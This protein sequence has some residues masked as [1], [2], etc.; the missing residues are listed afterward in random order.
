MKRNWKTAVIAVCAVVV[1]AA[2]FA[3]AA[4][5]QDD[6]LITLGYLKN[7]FTPQIETYVDEA[8]ALGTA[9]NQV[10]FDAALQEWDTQVN[11][12]IE[13]IENTPVT[14]N[15]ASFLTVPMA[16]GTTVTVEAGCELI[17]RTGTPVCSAALI[18]QTNGTVLAAGKTLTA[19]H[20]YLAL[21]SC[22]FSVPVQ[23]VTGVIT[24]GPLN[25]RAGAGSSYD[26][27][28][29]LQEGAVVTLVSDT[30]SGWYM[31][32]CDGLA[33]YVS[34]SYVKLNTVSSSGPV[35]FLIRGEYTAQ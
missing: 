33:G 8:V 6:P 9:Q 12:A 23:Q 14:V 2:G 18:D 26:I 30:G 32:T 7:I 5:S 13:E 3:A 4:G 35:S 31:I 11:E 16:E 15:P 1:L 29:T 21:E 28:G 27:L 22:S 19:N 20:L 10:D 25:V 34:A 17:L 24:A